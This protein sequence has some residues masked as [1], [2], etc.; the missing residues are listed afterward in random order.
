MSAK[1]SK[2]STV[3][4]NW[5]TDIG[6]ILANAMEKVC[7]DDVITVE[8]GKSLQNAASIAS[9]MLTTEVMIADKPAEKEKA[10]EA[11]PPAW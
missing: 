9:L 2:F 1:E 6:D 8:D 3:S 10:P 7:R 5:N 11:V 4:A